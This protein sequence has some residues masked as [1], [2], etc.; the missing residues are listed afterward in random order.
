MGCLRKKTSNWQ[1][2]GRVASAGG[3]SRLGS[4]G[5]PMWDGQ[6]WVLAPCRGS[7][8]CGF[9]R[10]EGMSA[11][12]FSPRPLTMSPESSSACPRCFGSPVSRW[13]YLGGFCSPEWEPQPF[14][15]SQMSLNRFISMH[16][17]VSPETRAGGVALQG[18]HPAM[19]S[20]HRVREPLTTKTT[21]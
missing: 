20:L 9:V 12:L 18:A 3:G 15:G 2:K 11:W 21:A 16:V 6:G 10:T 5:V 1:S 14:G 7:P 4:S 13:Q 19:G 17:D 8:W